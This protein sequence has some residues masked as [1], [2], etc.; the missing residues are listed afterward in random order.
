MPEGELDRAMDR[1]SER[2]Q[3]ILANDEV[4]GVDVAAMLRMMMSG[5]DLDPDEV[6]RCMAEMLTV[7]DNSLGGMVTP[8]TLALTFWLDGIV[9]GL[10]VAEERA[11]GDPS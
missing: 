8:I 1:R 2:Q 11:S 7:A 4:A 9:L 5:Q 3:A 6:D 10:M